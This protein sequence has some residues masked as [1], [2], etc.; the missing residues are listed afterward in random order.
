MMIGGARYRVDF[1][2]KPERRTLLIRPPSPPGRSLGPPRTRPPR[3]VPS[4][5]RAQ[6]ARRARRVRVSVFCCTV[7][8]LICRR[9]RTRRSKFARYF[10]D[11]L[12]CLFAFTSYYITHKHGNDVFDISVSSYIIRYD[13]M[14]PCVLLTYN[15]I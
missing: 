1:R 11:F 5:I 14:H 7:R 15:V 8:V 9:R 6:C 2:A 4:N 3:T 13:I 12:F 10:F